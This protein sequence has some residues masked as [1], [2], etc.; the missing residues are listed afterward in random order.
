[1]RTNKKNAANHLHRRRIA[2]CQRGRVTALVCMLGA[3][4]WFTPL[5]AIGEAVTDELQPEVPAWV[6]PLNPPVPASGAPYDDAKQL[7]VPNSKLAFTEAQLNDLFAAP[8][9]HPDSHAAMPS[10]V[11]RGNS[12]EVYACGFC[13]TPGGQG[14][15]E[16]ASLAG[17]PAAYIIQQVA[18]FKSGTRKSAWLAPYRPADLMIRVATHATADEVA[19]AAQYFSAQQLRPRVVVVERSRVPQSHVVGW[20]YVEDGRGGDEPL[21]ERLLEFA[22]DASRHENRDDEMR[23]I[24]Y[25]PAG[26]IGRGK[27][28]SQSGS[29]GLTVACMSCHGPSLRGTGLVPPIAGRSP[30]YILRQLLAF[31]TGARAGVTGQPMSAVVAKLKTRNMIDVAAYAASLPP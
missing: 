3:P 24:A 27:S 26:S 25:A 22:P 5:V 19:A 28:I 30:T 12:P 11:S 23:Y 29:I 21:G 9:W 2:N 17:L 20:V 18:D 1:M 4:I 14:R 10:V 7:H 16:N 6:F 15:P 31:Q 8:D 13:H